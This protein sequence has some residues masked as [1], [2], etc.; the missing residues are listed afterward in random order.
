MVGLAG[1]WVA[2]TRQNPQMYS[3]MVRSLRNVKGFSKVKILLLFSVH[4][5][6]VELLKWE[7]I[8]LLWRHS[9]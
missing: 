9:I 5:I 8:S 3:T 1:A 4:Y 7:N 2:K 6:T